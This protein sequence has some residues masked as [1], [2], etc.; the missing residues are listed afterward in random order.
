MLSRIRIRTIIV[1]RKKEENKYG[2]ENLRQGSSLDEGNKLKLIL[3][4]ECTR[5]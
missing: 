2:C 3:K 1:V 5:M 4:N